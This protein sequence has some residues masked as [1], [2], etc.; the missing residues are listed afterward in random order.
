MPSLRRVGHRGAG[1]H[2]PQNTLRSFERAIAMGVEMV[3]TDVRQARDGFLVLASSPESVRRFRVPPGDS[4][5]A[6]EV[7]LVRVALQG[8]AGYLRTYREPLA[9]FV[10]DA[11]GLPPK[12]VH[13]RL[14]ALIGSLE[15]FD[16]LE[17]TQRTAPEPPATPPQPDHRYHRGSCTAEPPIP[18]WS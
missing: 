3:E 6:A 5:P 8:W 11:H 2:E 14:D 18:C 4:P 17:V 10:A 13:A 12:E 1:A 9:A 15:P 16:M 7:P